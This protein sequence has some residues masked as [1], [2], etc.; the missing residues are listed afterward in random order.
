[1]TN[2]LFYFNQKLSFT[3]YLATNTTFFILVIIFD[4]SIIFQ[5]Q[6]FNFTI[7]IFA[8]KQNTP[9][10]IGGVSI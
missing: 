1:M 10:I 3:D 7:I 5:T 9:Y 8:K 6:F 4:K 2:L